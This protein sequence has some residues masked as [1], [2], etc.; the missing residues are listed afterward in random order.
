[1]VERII[2]IDPGSRYTGIG[3]IDKTGNQLK[4]VY[5]ET[6]ITASPDK[7]ERKLGLIGERL[8]AIIRHYQ[9]GTAAIEKIFHSIN[10]KTSIVLGQVRGAILL[11]LSQHQVDVYEYA[12]NAVKQA[13]VGAGKADKSQVAAMVKI[14]LNR[15]RSQ[16]LKEDEADALAVAI[17][18]ANTMDLTRLTSRRGALHSP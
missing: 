10:V 4:F 7:I 16:D 17:C 15:E 2:G 6:I 18:H 11:T 1:M 12:P 13:T 9:P 14:L 3:I 5:C 8:S